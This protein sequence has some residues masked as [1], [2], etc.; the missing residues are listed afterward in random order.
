LWN[1]KNF[2][3]VL[4]TLDEI[5]SI[6]DDFAGHMVILGILMLICLR[7]LVQKT[8]FWNS[9]TIM[10]YKYVAMSFLQMLVF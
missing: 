8:L 3:T 6:I 7:S 10:I 1:S 2:E 4:N 9:L 5:E